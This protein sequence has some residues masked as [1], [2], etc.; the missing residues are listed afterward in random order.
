MTFNISIVFICNFSLIL[1]KTSV[2]SGIDGVLLETLKFERLLPPL[3]FCFFLFISIFLCWELGIIVLPLVSSKKKPTQQPTFVQSPTF[4]HKPQYMPHHFALP[5]WLAI[6]V[7]IWW[8]CQHWLVV[9]GLTPSQTCME[10]FFWHFQR[11]ITR[12]SSSFFHPCSRV[13]HGFWY[14]MQNLCAVSIPDNNISF[15]WMQ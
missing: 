6:D 1:S 12:I 3:C 5:H 4:T 2:K 11:Q 10:I 7:A 15:C 14:I 9:S 8:L 13:C